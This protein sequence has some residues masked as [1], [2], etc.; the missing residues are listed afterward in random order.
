VRHAAAVLAVLAA[1]AGLAACGDKTLKTGELKD[2]IAAQFKAQGIPLHDISCPDGIKAKTGEAIHCTAL[3]PAQTKLVLDGKVLSVKDGKANFRVRAVR[4][5]ARGTVIASQ[6]RAMLEQRV[7]QKA[8][9]MTCPRE[10][11]IPTKP[12][13]T[14]ELQTLDGKRYDTTVTIDA[15]SRIN[16]QVAKQPKN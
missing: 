16:V 8:K 6:A 14:C 11:S 4:G 9:G 1:A 5:V 2:T 12:S 10:V 3:N 13:I 15:Q 7:G